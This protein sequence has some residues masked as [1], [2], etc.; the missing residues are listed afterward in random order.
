[1]IHSK[2]KK[3]IDTTPKGLLNFPKS[4]LCFLKSFLSVASFKIIG[5][6]YVIVIIKVYEL[7]NSYLVL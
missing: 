7:M 6:I 1:M 4:N 3:I 5:N 2:I